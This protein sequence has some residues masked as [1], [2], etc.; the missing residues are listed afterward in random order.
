MTL[1]WGF[2]FAAFLAQFAIL[3]C[4]VRIDKHWHVLSTCVPNEIFI[5]AEYTIPSF[6]LPAFKLFGGS[7]TAMI[8][9]FQFH[10]AAMAFFASVIAPFGG[11]F[12]SG[13]KRAF[14][15]KDFGDLIPGHGGL[16]GKY[17]FHRHR[18]YED[19]SYCIKSNTMI[20]FSYTSW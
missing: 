3:I 19:L 10:I 16:M 17:C 12:A 9:P 15:I 20:I 11:F 6:L 18:F 7:K 2:I 14:K 5:P 8:C 13:F 4:P 1:I